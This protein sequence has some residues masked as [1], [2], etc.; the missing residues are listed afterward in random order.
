MDYVLWLAGVILIQIAVLAFCIK[1]DLEQKLTP[2][3][4]GSLMALD[5]LFFWG[6][7]PAIAYFRP[8][9]LNVPSSI[10]PSTI[11]FI[12]TAQIGFLVTYYSALI[13]PSP[14]VKK[15]NG[16]SI[17]AARIVGWSGL[18]LGIAFHLIPALST[19][20]SIP[21]LNRPLWLMGVG[22]LT[23][24][25]VTRQMSGRLEAMLFVIV[26]TMKLS[27]EL[28]SGYSSYFINACFIV[29][30][31]LFMT[32][33]WMALLMSAGLVALTLASYIP[34]KKTYNWINGN[35]FFSAG[36]P[37]NSLSSMFN[38]SANLDHVT[39]RSAQSL[40]LE[41]VIQK[42]PSEVPF[43]E[44]STL[45][46]VVTNMVPRILWKDKPEEKLGNRFGRTYAV[47][48]ANDEATS[49]NVPWLVEFYMNF[50][51]T[52]AILCMLAAGGAIGALVRLIRFWP[53]MQQVGL[54]SALVI[55]LF[56]PESNMS[57]MVGSHLWIF[58]ILV[59]AFALSQRII[60]RLSR[61]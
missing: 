46:G 40:L 44:G 2:I 12:L 17:K 10:P 32:R 54:A 7:F 50:G 27:L 24:A 11:L 19:L 21:Q 6:I 28:T 26:L 42:T 59:M 39:R 37:S 60:A 14:D 4:Y 34:I 48:L 49:W 25:L 38:P 56:H 9:G 61:S 45:L 53:P 3:P 8:R 29:I 16:A 31:I 35:E 23:F 43:W 57:L 55:P 47:I 22:I 18:L 20:P 15:D 36:G 51:K 41:Q 1:I 30:A 52:G 5:N 13:R 33:R 58:L